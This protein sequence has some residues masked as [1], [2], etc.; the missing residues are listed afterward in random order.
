MTF[1][2]IMQ[3]EVRLWLDLLYRRMAGRVSIRVPYYG[4]LHRSIPLQLFDEVKRLIWRS[5]SP[6]FK[7]PFCAVGENRKAVVISFTS[8][9]SLVSLFALLSGL[10]S[11]EVRKHFS[12]TL[13][14]ATRN[15]HKV[16]LIVSP[17]KDFALVYKRRNGQLTLQF[18]YGEWNT[19]GT[20]W[21][22]CQLDNQEG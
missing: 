21:H 11:G 3:T 10:S 20:P 12:R 9:C 15:G 16:K 6:R 1:A 13:K 2:S 18:H 5:V 7:E 19:Y 17:D 8:L 22:P 4:E 14:S